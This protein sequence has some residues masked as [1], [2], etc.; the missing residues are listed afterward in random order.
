MARV[1]ELL[2]LVPVEFPTT[3]VAGTPAERAR[4][5]NAAFAD[6]SIRAIF[7][8]IGGD[9]QITLLRHLDPAGPQRDPKPYFGY[10]DSTNVLNWLWFHGVASVHGGST[11]V[12]LGPGTAVDDEHLSSLR[13]ALFGGDVELHPVARSR[14]VGFP[15]DDPRALTTAP[16]R[17]G[18]R[19]VDMGR[20]RAIGHRHDVGRQPRD[21]PLELRRWPLDS[22]RDGVCRVRPVG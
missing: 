14:D 4:D 20:A 12:H 9:D 22:P 2:G 17:R 8:T 5:L 15:W 21:S 1:V 3:R 19:A 10:S 18:G 16:P 6:E 13:A 11:Q 7:A